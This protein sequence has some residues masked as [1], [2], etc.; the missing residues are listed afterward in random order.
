[1]V[2]LRLQRFG[3]KRQPSYRIVAAD[4]R[5]ARNGA[6]I[7]QLGTYDPKVDPPEIRM[8]VDRVEYWLDNG[9][10]PSD[11]VRSFVKRMRQEESPV[12]DLS[13]EGA[14]QAHRE[15]L[16]RQ[17]EEEIE[18]RRAE[19]AEASEEADEQAEDEP[20]EQEAADEASADE[21]EQDDAEET[22]E[23]EADEPEAAEDTDGDEEEA[24]EEDASEED[25]SDEQASED[26]DD[27]EDDEKDES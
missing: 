10:R 2:R 17:R 9:A 26:A 16:R 3:A 27:D 21:P 18:E 6:F 13:E 23:E 1:M 24:S 4:Q 12:V 15:E 25:A 22:Q 19:L 20:D 14:D 5:N 7:E 8:N 11:T